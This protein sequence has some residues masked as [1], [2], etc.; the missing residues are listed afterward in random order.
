MVW[1]EACLNFE[2]RGSAG[3]RGVLLINESG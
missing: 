2:G 1:R 3:V